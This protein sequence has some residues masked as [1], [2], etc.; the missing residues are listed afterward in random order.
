MGLYDTTTTPKGI[1]M[2]RNALWFAIGSAT[3]AVAAYS[4][5]VHLIRHDPEFF[6]EA[7]DTVKK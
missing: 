1:V 6:Q 3:T 7:V 5:A 4:Y 2:R